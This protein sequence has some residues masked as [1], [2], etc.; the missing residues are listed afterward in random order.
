MTRWFL[1]WLSTGCCAA[2]WFDPLITDLRYLVL[3][4]GDAP[5]LGVREFTDQNRL[6][7]NFEKM[8]LRGKIASRFNWNEIPLDFG[9]DR[10][11]FCGTVVAVVYC[12]R[13]CE[14]HG[15]EMTLTMSWACQWYVEVV[16]HALMS[17]LSV[18]SCTMLVFVLLS[19]RFWIFTVHLGALRN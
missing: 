1:F 4:I 14:G 5:G 12:R 10:L 2:L 6:S 9:N 18:S 17:I 13:G 11:R 19:W 3:E 16:W 7:R 8:F 15:K